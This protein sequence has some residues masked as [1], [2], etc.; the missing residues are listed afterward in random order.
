MWEKIRSGLRPLHSCL[1]WLFLSCVSGIVIGAVAAAFHH[2]ISWATELRLSHPWVLLLLPAAGAGIVLLYRVCGME[3]DRGTNQVLLAIRKAEPIRLRTAPL[4]FLSTIL[5][6][7]VGGSAG[8][9]GAALQLG[10]SMA[11]AAGGMLKLDAGERRI[12]VMC[13]MSAAFSALFGTPLTAAVF[14]LEV[15]GVGVMYYA[16]I[17]PCLFS[18]LTALELAKLLGVHP[19]RYVIS[20]IPDVDPAS[21]VRVLGM[22]ALCAVL[23]ILFCKTM[24]TAAHIYRRLI[25]RP[26]LRAVLG[27]VLLLA[28][29]ALVG[30]QDY[31]G[32]GG[33]VIE[34]A[35]H[36]EVGAEAFLLKVLFTAVTLG[37]GFRGGEIVPVLFTGAAFGSVAGPL[38]GLSASFGGALGM[39]GVFCGATNCP[40]ASVFLAYELFGGQALPLYALCCAVSYMLS[41][42][43]GLYSEQKIVYS[44][45]RTEWVDK[46]AQ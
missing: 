21:M 3:Q 2:G 30:N 12:L 44:K 11:D 7:L 1:R 20:E 40:I 28:L 6:H 31:N 23:A 17:V 8:R 25:K 4:I 24:H 26:V 33:A 41:G 5:T 22:G 36:G 10:G 9:E 45:Y 37:A 18:A 29:T 16:A 35:L 42:Y 38:L 32:A 19:E 39:A 43:S 15:V 46:Y 14:S 34:R 27:G 13:G